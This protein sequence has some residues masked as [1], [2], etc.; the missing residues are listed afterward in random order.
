MTDADVD[1]SHIQTLLL[2]FFLPLYAPLV[3]QGHVFVQPPRLLLCA[4]ERSYTYLFTD[5]DKD[6][7]LA[8]IPRKDRKSVY[9]QRYQGP[10][11]K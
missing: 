3:D 7:T 8:A 2:T 4:T 6:A 1:G 5:E 11:V 10:W 9:V